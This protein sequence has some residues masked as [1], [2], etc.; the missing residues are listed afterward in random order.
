V[1]S[2]AI[3]R[4]TRDDARFSNHAKRRSRQ[5]GVRDA[6]LV[7]LLFEADREV[8]VGDGCVAMSISRSRRRELLAE[9]HPPSTV[10]RAAGIAAVES[11]DGE[12]VTVLRPHGH[13]GRRYRKAFRSH[14]S[15]MLKSA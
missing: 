10:D 8:P 3:Q 9:G 1:N 11:A 2:A 7:L 15:K 14:E 13:R 6:D 4:Y 5:R 12:I